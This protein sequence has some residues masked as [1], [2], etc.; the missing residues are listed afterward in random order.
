[1]ILCECGCPMSRVLDNRSNGE[2]TLRIRACV[3][4]GRLLE[5]EERLVRVRPGATKN[6]RVKINLPVDGLDEE[7]LGIVR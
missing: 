4:C 5:T 7:N 2:A 3:E 6:A 1:M